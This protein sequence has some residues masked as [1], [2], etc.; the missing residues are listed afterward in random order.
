MRKDSKIGPFKLRKSPPVRLVEMPLQRTCFRTDL[1]RTS[2]FHPSALPVHLR[3]AQ[4]GRRI[5]QSTDRAAGCMLAGSNASD[6]QADICMCQERS[7]CCCSPA[8]FYNYS[9]SVEPPHLVRQQ[10]HQMTFLA[11]SSSR[12]PP[13][14]RHHSVVRA[15]TSALARGLMVCH[16]GFLQRH[17]P[18]DS[19]VARLR[20]SR[21]PVRTFSRLSTKVRARQWL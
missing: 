6:Q 18:C 17:A 16:R 12:A 2:C 1:K 7:A 8:P 4:S 10:L 5:R 13:F 21:K 3:T 20:K 19:A 11:L 9:R 14:S 15:C